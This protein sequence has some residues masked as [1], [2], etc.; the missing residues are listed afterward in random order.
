MTIVE[1]YWDD[2]REGDTCTSPTYVVTKERIL[3][4]ADLTGDHTP[5]HVDEEYANASHFGCLVAHGLFG[6]SVADG[7]KTQSDYRFLPGMSLGWTW[8]FLLPIKVGDVLHVTFRVGSMR[9]SKS[10]PDWGIVVLPSELINQDGQVVQRGEH[11]LM[12]P[13]RPEAL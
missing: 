7:L 8:D 1:K 6:L 10:R 3:A 13:R 5:V 11:R 4:Y 12:V 9:A 2:A